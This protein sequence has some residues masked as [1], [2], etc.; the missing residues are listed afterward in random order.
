MYSEPIAA[1]QR[2]FA[3]GDNS[4]RGFALDSLSPQDPDAPAGSGE[5]VI[6]PVPM[7]AL[8]YRADYVADP[9]AGAAACIV[10]M[11]QGSLVTSAV[12]DDRAW[13]Q[14]FVMGAAASLGCFCCFYGCWWRVVEG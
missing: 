7:L 2:F 3:G 12:S 10:S 9:T 14:E 11:G 4:V 1:S 6:T 13:V 5:N 8:R